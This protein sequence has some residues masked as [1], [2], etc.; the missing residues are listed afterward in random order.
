[1]SRRSV[2]NVDWRGFECLDRF[3]ALF[4]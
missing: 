3:H 4:L 2:V 1:V